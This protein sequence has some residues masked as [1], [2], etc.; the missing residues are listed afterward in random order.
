M[1]ERKCFEKT[2]FYEILMGVQK[3][4][5]EN[6][7]HVTAAM[8]EYAK[9]NNRSINSVHTAYYTGLK[10]LKD[11]SEIINHYESKPKE[12]YQEERVKACNEIIDIINT[13]VKV[14]DACHKYAVEHEMDSLTVMQNY[15]QWTKMYNI[16]R[17]KKMTMRKKERSARHRKYLL[18]KKQKQI[19][20]SIIIREWGGSKTVKEIIEK[21]YLDRDYDLHTYDLT[22]RACFLTRKGLI[23]PRE[24]LWYLNRENAGKYKHFF[25]AKIGSWVVCKLDD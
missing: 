23:K 22:R 25:N 15:Y 1:F 3:L 11:K 5:K 9:Q 17:P 4:M 6:D 19:I 18:S 12:F 8:E 10:Y 20:D 24:K 14:I 13:G 2:K 21:Y 16:D 7:M